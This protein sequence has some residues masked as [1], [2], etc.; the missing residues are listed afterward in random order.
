MAPSRL[1]IVVSAVRTSL[2][3][4]SSVLTML[5]Y[6][7]WG[8]LPSAAIIQVLPLSRLLDLYDA[9]QD[10]ANLLQLHQFRNGN[11]KTSSVVSALRAKNIVLNTSTAK[12]IG[13]IGNLFGLDGSAANLGHIED[14]AARIVDRWSVE[15]APMS[16]VHTNGRLAAA[17]AKTLNSRE[18]RR[19]DVMNT[20][21]RG[22]QRGAETMAHY[23]RRGRPQ[24]RR[25]RSA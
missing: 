3:D 20:F 23:S 8:T 25:G 24:T 7:V 17:F 22:V 19:Q 14:V 9:D 1:V 4:T 2:Y 6:M 18:H 5:E 15:I 10:V 21:I 11:N 13:R 16:D 12:A